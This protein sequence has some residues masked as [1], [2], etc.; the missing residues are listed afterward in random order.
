MSYE[1]TTL[2][3]F[4]NGQYSKSKIIIWVEIFPEEQDV[5]H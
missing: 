3:H 4:A 5:V 2:V 1:N